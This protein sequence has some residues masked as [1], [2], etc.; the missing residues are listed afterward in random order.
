MLSQLCELLL[1]LLMRYIFCLIMASYV[2]CFSGGHTESAMQCMLSAGK[3]SQ[4]RNSLY[5]EWPRQRG[6]MFERHQGSHSAVSSKVCLSFS[7]LCFHLACNG[8]IAT[9]EDCFTH[10]PGRTPN[11][12]VRKR[13][14]SQPSPLMT[15]IHSPPIVYSM[16]LSW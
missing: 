7:M 9:K 12:F 4:S 5:P 13:Y 14:K 16:C 11:T 8:F 2:I 3:S 1:Y 6:Q 15:D 10:P